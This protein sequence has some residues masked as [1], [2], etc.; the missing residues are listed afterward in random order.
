L[1]EAG[2]AVLILA[3]PGEEPAA[4]QL[5]ASAGV[6]VAAVCAPPLRVLAA[7]IAA[8]ELFV[9]GD[10]GPMHLAWAVGAP[11]VAIYGPTDPALNAPFGEGHCVLAPQ[12]PTRR[13]DPDPFPGITPQL[14]LNHALERL[15]RRASSENRL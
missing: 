9:G 13:D 11:V 1:A 5:A 8:C 15:A 4:R 3:G 6:G 7:V 2:G 14:I 10:T 12:R